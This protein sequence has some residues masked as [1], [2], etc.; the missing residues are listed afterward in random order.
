MRLFPST[1]GKIRNCSLFIVH[2][3]LCFFL[4]P[5]A[6]S[7]TAIAVPD[8]SGRPPDEHPILAPCSRHDDRYGEL[9]FIFEFVEDW[10]DTYHE[11]VDKVIE[12]YL[13]PQEY[14][15]DAESFEEL[16]PPG[17]ELRALA[18]KMPTW[19]DP[20]MPLSSYDIGWVLLEYLRMYE[21]ALMEFA[22]AESFDTTL[23]EFRKPDVTDLFYPDIEPPS[24][25][26][27]AVINEERTIARKTLHRVLTLIGNFGR[28]RPLEA[29]LECAQRLS[30][31][32]RNI[33]ALSAETSSCLP[34]AW[35]AK[36][37]LRDTLEE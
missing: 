31:D 4:F 30:L 28:L 2:C 15:C 10:P 22:D 11:Q 16:L 27:A 37:A 1:K 13:E 35:N 20:D 19:Q 23:E 12:E 36:D 7:S 3:S 9:E 24:F 25:V 8:Y 34:R 6:A 29:E 5:F 14:V 17:E 21:C 26:N 18:D 33:A 32:V